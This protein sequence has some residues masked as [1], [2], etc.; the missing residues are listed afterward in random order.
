MECAISKRW[1]NSEGL[2]QRILLS[3][4]CRGVGSLCH[5]ASN[6]ETHGIHLLTARLR[7]AKTNKSI[8][9]QLVPK[10]FE[11]DGCVLVFLYHVWKQGHWRHCISLRFASGVGK[12]SRTQRM[13]SSQVL[14]SRWRKEL[15]DKPTHKEGAD[16]KQVAKPKTH[17]SHTKEPAGA[18]PVRPAMMVGMRDKPRPK[19]ARR[20][21]EVLQERLP[22]RRVEGPGVVETEEGGNRRGGMQLY[23]CIC[24]YSEIYI[25]KL[26]LMIIYMYIIEGS[27]NSKLPTIWRVEK[28]MKSR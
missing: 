22:R 20:K 11:E 2:S 16:P 15:E 21:S 25:Y 4:P 3:N 14:G 26:H 27:L 7:V 10:F 28:Q 19:F 8:M 18:K 12:P 24:I 6:A 5:H 23:I 9:N 17:A 13:I 1:R